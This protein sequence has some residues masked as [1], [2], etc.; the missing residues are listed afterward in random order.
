MGLP[1]IF[2]CPRCYLP[3]GKCNCTGT[4]L[5]LIG[6]SVEITSRTKIACPMCGRS[7]HWKPARLQESREKGK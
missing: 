3:L 2:P 1:T 4:R 5:T 6:S 7:A